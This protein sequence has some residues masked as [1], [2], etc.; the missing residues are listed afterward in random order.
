MQ[1]CH[2]V[3]E[4]VLYISSSVEKFNTSCQKLISL[5]GFNS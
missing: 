1:L 4:G 3:A 2:F 5:D